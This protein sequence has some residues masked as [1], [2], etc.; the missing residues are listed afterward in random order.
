M[1]FH[2]RS[3]SLKQIIVNFEAFVGRDSPHGRN[4][5]AINGIRCRCAPIL[6]QKQTFFHL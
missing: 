5:L 2:R 1:G 3:A 4:F 6:E